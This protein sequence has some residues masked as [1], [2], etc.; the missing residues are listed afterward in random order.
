MAKTGE[1]EKAKNK[2][3]KRSKRHC[4]QHV[5]G[6]TCIRELNT[7]VDG[8]IMKQ[9][10]DWAL[11]RICSSLICAPLPHSPGYTHARGAT[12][13]II[14]TTTMLAQI[15]EVSLNDRLIGLPK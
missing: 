8:V 4:A 14:S 3:E 1:L 6:K 2:E 7:E 5:V 9:R 10:L 12:R 15:R 11:R 13:Q